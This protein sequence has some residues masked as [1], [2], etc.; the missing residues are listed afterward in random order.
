MSEA[1]RRNGILLNV[2][3]DG[4][5]FSGFARQPKARTI[6][7]ELDGAVRSIDPNAS[8]V[9]GSSRTDA[10]VHARAQPVAFDTDREIPT[11]GWVLALLAELPKEISVWRAARVEVGYDP[12][13]HALSKTYRYAILESEIRDPFL[14][15]RAWRVGDRLNQ[16]LMQ[17]ELDALPGEHDFAGFRAAG[18]ARDETVRRI[19]R[20]EVRRAGSDRRLLE[21]EVEGDRF[22]YKM[23][24]IIAGTVVDVGRGRLAPGAV[25]R[26]LETRS[27]DTLGMTAPPDGLYLD[28]VVL[29]DSGTGEWPEVPRD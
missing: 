4:T 11:R 16:T 9:R 19:V 23:M 5:A 13:R 17:A 26:G 8:Q 15:H 3:Y 18:D 22:L 20:A 12:R 29:D 27:R 24:R 25:K 21:L 6:A 1:P 10:G 2:A 14:A 28:R 7:G